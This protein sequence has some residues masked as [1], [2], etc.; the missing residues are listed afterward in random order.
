V[1]LPLRLWPE[2]PSSQRMVENSSTSWTRECSSVCFHIF[3]F[4][5]STLTDD[6]VFFSFSQRRGEPDEI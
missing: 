5:L 2:N 4:L 1:P 3:S 6:F